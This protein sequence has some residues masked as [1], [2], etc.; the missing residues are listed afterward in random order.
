M[1]NQVLGDYL[2]FLVPAFV[3]PLGLYLTDETSSP[4]TLFKLGLLFPLFLL[5]MKGLAGFFPPENLRERSVARIAEYAILQGLVFAAFMSMF[6]GFM[7]PELQSSFLSTLGQF[8][9]AAVPVAA[10]HFVSA[11]NAQKKLGAS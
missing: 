6:G 1:K 5:A 7:Q 8:A 9:F 10:F 11:L 4:T 2:I 3:I